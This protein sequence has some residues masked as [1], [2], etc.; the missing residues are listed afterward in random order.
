MQRLGLLLA[1]LIASY[2]MLGPS[3]T[4]QAA[5]RTR[6]FAETGFCVSDPILSYWERNGGLAVFGYPITEQRTETVENW[7]GPVQWF[8]RDRLEDHGTQGVMAGRLGAQ[9][10][11]VQ[12]RP[13]EQMPKVTGAP[14][15]CRFFAETGHSLCEPFLNYWN[16]NG[17]LARFGYPI[18]E[19][20]REILP[21]WEGA[22][23]YFERRRMEHHLENEGTP[24]EVLL[25]LLGR[26]MY[27]LPECAP[28]VPPLQAT[29]NAYPD[30]LGC[31]APYP[32]PNVQIA[33]EPFER[34]SMLWVPPVS[35][36]STGYI[37]VVYFDQ[38]RGSLVWQLYPDTWTPSDPVSGG[39]TPPP[40]LYEP[41]RGFGKLWRENAEVRNT[42]GWATAPERADTG[43]WQYFKG[44]AWLIHRASNDRIYIMY[45][46]QRADDITRIK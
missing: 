34:G 4:A 37:W 20:L 24:Y 16:N 7:T 21:S 42:L 44:G 28:A 36:S 9:L 12:N 29:A 11:A 5:P 27:R 26:D 2:G 3:T 8:E 35:P 14:S 43:T 19:P 39:Q 23:Q 1:V 15:G 22:V 45:P 30:V 25:G 32:Q 18:S 46:D 10:L 40:G 13:W 17:G 6:C 41:I 33:T 38:T 31:P